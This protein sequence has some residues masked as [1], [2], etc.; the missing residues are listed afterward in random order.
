[1]TA[2]NRRSTVLETAVLLVPAA[3]YFA[4]AAQLVHVPV[5]TGVILALSLALWRA[6]P[7]NDRTVTYFAVGS[8]ALAI[9]LSNAFPMPDNR[10]S[11]LAVLLH[12]EVVVPFLLYMAA[13]FTVFRRRELALGMSAGALL[14]LLAFC[15]EQQCFYETGFI[16]T[17]EQHRA[18]VIGLYMRAGFFALLVLET[19]GGFWMLRRTYH[20]GRAA[21]LKVEYVLWY[22]LSLTEAG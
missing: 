11:F 20:V 5:V 21:G 18:Q 2:P 12:P 3:V 16:R 8:L 19:L 1:M 13:F 22:G 10:F 15:G 4:F 9:L 7:V 14:A 6:I 17:E